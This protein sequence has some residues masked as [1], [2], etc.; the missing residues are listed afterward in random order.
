MPRLA[1][2]ALLAAPA[3]AQPVASEADCRL[4]ADFAASV[5]SERDRGLAREEA[6]P[7]AY[8]SGHGEG[9]TT[10]ILDLVYDGNAHPPET[11]AEAVM[12]QCMTGYR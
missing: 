3:A 6:A 10:A 11:V 7:G 12:Y 8:Q 9:V 1:I 4:L 2:L 5:A